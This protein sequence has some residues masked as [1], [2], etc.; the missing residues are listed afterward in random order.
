MNYYSEHPR[1]TASRNVCEL[2]AHE[3][4]MQGMMTTTCL[5]QACDLSGAY[6]VAVQM[7]KGSRY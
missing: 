4:A 7:R 5:M 2:M 1:Q 3:L 6:I